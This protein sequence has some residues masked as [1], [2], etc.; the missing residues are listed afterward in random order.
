[1]ISQETYKREKRRLALA[2]GKFRRA[3]LACPPNPFSI[4]LGE[5]GRKALR[6]AIYAAR[7]LRAVAAEGIDLFQEQG[8]PDSWHRW[9]NAG[10][11]AHFY[12]QRAEDDARMLGMI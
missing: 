4:E 3:R 5:E 9:Q 7:K 10:E 1:V 12:L 6:D 11:D 8:Y 2:E